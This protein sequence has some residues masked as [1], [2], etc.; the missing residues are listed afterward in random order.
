MMFLVG[1]GVGRAAQVAKKVSQL[2]RKQVSERW[3]SASEETECGSYFK[4]ASGA[5]TP[6]FQILGLPPIPSLLHVRKI[7]HP[8]TLQGRFC[9]ST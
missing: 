3:P 8:T 1:R 2:D 4:A 9:H 7:P 6:V 5:I